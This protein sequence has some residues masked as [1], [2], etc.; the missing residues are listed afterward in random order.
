MIFALKQV[1]WVLT[2]V[3]VWYQNGNPDFI[4]MTL[5]PSTSYHKLSMQRT[6]VLE[7]HLTVNQSAETSLQRWLNFSKGS[8]TRARKQLSR[9]YVKYSVCNQDKLTNQE[10]P[11]QTQNKASNQ[12]LLGV[13][14]IMTQDKPEA[15]GKPAA[16][17]QA[18]ILEA[19]AAA[20]SWKNS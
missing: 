1:F 14:A 20:N 5:L 9:I 8:R 19:A 10:T 4:F 16:S 3:D 7:D 11:I 17:Q 13:T 18:K 15:K 12:I 2:H 6:G